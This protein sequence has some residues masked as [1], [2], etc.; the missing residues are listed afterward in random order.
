VNE[1]GPLREHRGAS[2][3]TSFFVGPE[4]SAATSLDEVEEMFE[5]WWA[6]KQVLEHT[7]D[8]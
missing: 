5:K 8:E 6:I 7:R 4:A 3:E 1:V 2:R